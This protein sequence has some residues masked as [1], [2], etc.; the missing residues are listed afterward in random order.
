MCPT[1]TYATR[2]L[3]PVQQPNWTG[4]GTCTSDMFSWKWEDGTDSLGFLPWYYSGPGTGGCAYFSS[5]YGGSWNDA[6]CSGQDL[7][8]AYNVICEPLGQS[9]PLGEPCSVHGAG[10]RNLAL[11]FTS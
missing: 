10:V 6:A 8:N 5:Y 1:L 3:C 2:V 7:S 11:R 4:A 9:Q